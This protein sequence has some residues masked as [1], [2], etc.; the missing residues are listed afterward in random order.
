MWDT[1]YNQTHIPVSQ[2]KVGGGGVGHLQSR[3]FLLTEKGF[4]IAEDISIG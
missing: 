4:S 2:G 3:I 1:L